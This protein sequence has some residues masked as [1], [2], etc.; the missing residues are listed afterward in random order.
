MGRWVGGSGRPLFVPVIAFRSAPRLVRHCLASP[1]TTLLGPPQ[2]LKAR[3]LPSSRP[4]AR[5]SSESLAVAGPAH[6][7]PCPGRARHQLHG[8]WLPLHFGGLRQDHAAVGHGD[9]AGALGGWVFLYHTAPCVR[10]LGDRLGGAPVLFGASSLPPRPPPLLPPQVVRTLNNGKQHYCGV[11]HP[12]A[13][14][15]NVLMTGCQVLRAL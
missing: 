7:T 15:Q 8:R 5:A 11:F 4:A 12:E 3:A 9:G 2:T 13:D 14:K 1:A 10:V 6:P